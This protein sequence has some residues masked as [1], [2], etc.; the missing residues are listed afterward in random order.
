VDESAIGGRGTSDMS[1]DR[2]C[3]AGLEPGFRPGGPFVAMPAAP[4]PEVLKAL[5]SAALV[6]DELAVRGFGLCLDV[7][8]E[9]RTVRVGVT[10]ADGRLVRRLTATV[11]LDLLADGRADEFLAGVVA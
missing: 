4:P 10:H 3:L 9:S 6:L 7:T 5:G 11:A 8:A 2:G 1:T